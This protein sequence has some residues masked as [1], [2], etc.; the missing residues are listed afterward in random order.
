MA[1]PSESPASQGQHERRAQAN[2]E[3]F[4]SASR[5][6]SDQQEESCSQE[7]LAPVGQPS[8]GAGEPLHPKAGPQVADAPAMLSAVSIENV[9]RLL[10]QQA[11]CCALTGRRLTPQTAALD[12]IVPIRF[13]GEHVIEN[14]QVLHKDVNRAKGSL[15]SD[16]FIGMCH[17][18]VRWSDL[19]IARKESQ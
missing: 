19:H 17:D 8:E 18:V 1:N 12:H 7:R 5:R 15:T 9:L 13:G 4:R 3:G 11:Y 2:V 6:N 10:D 16:E 14:V